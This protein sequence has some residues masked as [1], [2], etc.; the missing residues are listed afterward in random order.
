[1]TRPDLATIAH[2]VSDLPLG[3]NGFW[4]LAAALIGAVFNPWMVFYQQ[5]PQPKSAS[6]T[7]T[8]VRRA[9]IRPSERC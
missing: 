4:L 8:T 7:G 9:A 6:T 3:N 1:M 5:L 2:Q